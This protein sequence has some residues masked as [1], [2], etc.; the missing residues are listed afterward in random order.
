MIDISELR[1]KTL[2]DLKKELERL[3]KDAQKVVSEVTQKKEK[4]VSKIRVFKKDI[5][6]IQTLI[7][8][9]LKEVKGK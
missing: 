5:A 2:E 6:R 3:K 9:K 1:K 8:E 7:S 4:N